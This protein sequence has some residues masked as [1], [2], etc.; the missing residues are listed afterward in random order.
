MP[1][2]RCWYPIY[3]QAAAHIPTKMP[4]PD[5]GFKNTKK[6]ARKQKSPSFTRKLGPSGGCFVRLET[7]KDLSLAEQAG[8]EPAVG[9]TP[10]TLSRRVT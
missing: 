5:R 3:Q 10:R 7:D 4:T 1:P 8:F 6:D 2:K 9:F